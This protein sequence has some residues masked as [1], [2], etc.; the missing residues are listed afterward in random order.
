[1][2]RGPSPRGLAGALEDSSRWTAVAFVAWSGPVT[3]RRA[4][5]D[6]QDIR[7][8]AVGPGRVQRRA[9]RGLSQAC[10]RAGGGRG[11]NG[12]PTASLLQVTAESQE[13][14]LLQHHGVFLLSWAAVCC[15]FPGQ[16]PPAPC[17]PDR[18]GCLPLVA[19]GPSLLSNLQTGS[20]LHLGHRQPA[21]MSRH[22]RT[23]RW[24]AGT[25]CE[26][27]SWGRGS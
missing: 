10:L 7:T 23:S 2:K 9:E 3:G 19:G 12:Q 21:G 26:G 11:N 8:G 17:T 27:G 13:C 14:H 1:M 25:A 15:C 4:P 5:P 6:A 18:A 22:T 24:G 20:P 16:Q